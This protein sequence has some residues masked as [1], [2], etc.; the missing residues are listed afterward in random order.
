MT[1]VTLTY[2]AVSVDF[3]SSTARLN[4]FN[5]RFTNAL[6]PITTPQKDTPLSLSEGVG[7]NTIVMNIGFIT[8]TIDLVFTL[9]DGP[10]TFDF[11][12]PT[13]NYEKIIYMASFPRNVKTITLNGGS[14]PKS[15]NCQISSVNIPWD[16]GKKD[17]MS[18][19]MSVMLCKD[20][21]M[22]SA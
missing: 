19:T 2:G 15:Y 16:E 8:H 18:G 7:T 12:S 10:G 4:K 11:L 9:K 22:G 3:S 5:H 21:V 14:S 6:I 17:L 13:T 1:G 20:V